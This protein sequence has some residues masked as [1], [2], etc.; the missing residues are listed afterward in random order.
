MEDVSYKITMLHQCV[1]HCHN[2]GYTTTKEKVSAL[3]LGSKVDSKEV[4]HIFYFHPMLFCKNCGA[5]WTT[6]FIRDYSQE[7]AIENYNMY[8]EAGEKPNDCHIQ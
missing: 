2:C 5:P 1:I 8:K 3:Y 6:Y 4:W 7:E